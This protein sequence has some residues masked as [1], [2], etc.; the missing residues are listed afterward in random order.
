MTSTSETAKKLKICHNTLRQWS[1][2]G[3]IKFTLTAGGHRRYDVST[4][5]LP[6]A[7]KAFPEGSQSL[8]QFK[9]HSETQAAEEKGAVYCRVSSWKQKD[10]LERQDQKL[11]ALYP[12]HKVYKDV[13]SG[14][15]YKR[16]ALT[17]LLVDVQE[18]RIKQVVVA[19]K[20]RLAR[21]GTEL[22]AWIIDRAGASLV[23]LEGDNITAEQELTQ[24]LLAIVHVFSCRLNGKRRYTKAQQGRKVSK[25]RALQKT[26]ARDGKR[27]KARKG[28]APEDGQGESDALQ[29][30]R[31]ATNTQT[32]PGH[33]QVVQGCTTDLQPLHGLLSPTSSS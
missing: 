20:D 19:H 6:N 33:P 12:D 17:R 4:L 29:V 30:D 31:T 32:A 21:F 9:P 26:G 10:D 11:Q 16:K 8:G 27:T 24:D 25:K 23:I 28:T 14:L 22:I 2:K 7:P 18:G 3:Y 13:C 5:R 15:K 1:K